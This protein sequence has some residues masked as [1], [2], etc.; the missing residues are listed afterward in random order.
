MYEGVGFTVNTME[1]FIL[2]FS[3]RLRFLSTAD[4]LG[5]PKT[6]DLRQRISLLI[7]ATRDIAVSLGV[8][9]F[10]VFVLL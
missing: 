10:E 8:L 7:V 9:F 1:P 5:W 6:G 3:T 2:E 4:R